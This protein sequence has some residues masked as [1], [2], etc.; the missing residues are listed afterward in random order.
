MAEDDHSRYHESREKLHVMEHERAAEAADARIRLLEQ[1]LDRM[2]KHAHR[3]A[4]SDEYDVEEE[5]DEE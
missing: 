4:S 5:E 3:H 2:E 1:R